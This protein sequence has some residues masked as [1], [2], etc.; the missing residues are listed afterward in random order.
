MENDRLQRLSVTMG[1]VRELIVRELRA[2]ADGRAA[3]SRTLSM[4][5]ELLEVLWAELRQVS[6]ERERLHRLGK[7]T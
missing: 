5:L 1:A 2:S 4:T 3:S 7:S 6:D